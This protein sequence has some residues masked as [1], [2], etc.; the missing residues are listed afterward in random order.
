MRD[1]YTVAW[2]LIPAL[3]QCW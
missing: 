3:N 2:A 1:Y